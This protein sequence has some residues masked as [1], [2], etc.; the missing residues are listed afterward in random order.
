[1]E[2]KYI[3]LSTSFAEFIQNFAPFLQDI[4]EKGSFILDEILDEFEN[5]LAKYCGVKYAIAV[6]SG[7][8]ALF[9]T[10]KALGIGPGDEVITVSNTFIATVGSIVA[11]G[12]MPKLVDVRYNDLLID[13]EDIE[14][15]ITSRT[16]AI[17][18]VHLAGLCCEMDS[19][20]DLAQKYNLFVIEDSAQAIGATYKGKKAGSFGIAGCFSLN[21][22]KNLGGIGDGGAIVTDDISLYNKLRLLRNHGLLNREE[23]VMWG[24]NSRLDS[25]NAAV[26]LAKISH[27]ESIIQYKQKLADL[28]YE[29]LAP[30]KEKEL[31]DFFIPGQDRRHVYHL[32]I[33]K[34]TDRNTL[35][36]YLIEKGIDVRIHYPIP[37]HKQRPFIDSFG[38]ITLKNTEKLAKA[39][40]SLPIHLKMKYEDVLEVST[41][42]HNFYLKSRKIRSIK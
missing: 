21:P 37:V 22:L 39:I 13:P 19:I 3:D 1:M 4:F 7:T 36:N 16:K 33:I 9:L 25:I 14:K 31:I 5:Q 40:I 2:I 35:Y 30:L 11:S 12:A 20:L 42:I 6:N 28:Y 23:A 38:S 27:L 41:W 17:I 26:L 32:F 34:V 8:D 18:P 15:N 29:S 24:Y 10:L